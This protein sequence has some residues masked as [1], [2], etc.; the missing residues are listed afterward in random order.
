MRIFRDPFRGGHDILVMCETYKPEG[1]GVI[2][3]LS[4]LPT[5][6]TC[7]VHGNNTRF[8]ALQIFEN[9]KV[10][11]QKPWYVFA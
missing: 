10:A 7:G 2:T 6:G 3:P 4:H 1:R 11:E 9:P 8:H 5:E